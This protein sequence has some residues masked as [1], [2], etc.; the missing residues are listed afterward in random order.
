MDNN[1]CNT[2]ISAARSSMGMDYESALAK[3]DQAASDFGNSSRKAFD[4]GG[5]F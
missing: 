1:E 2:V 5:E 4:R 3:I